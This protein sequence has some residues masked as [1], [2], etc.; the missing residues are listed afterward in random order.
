MGERENGR[1]EV[2]MQRGPKEEERVCARDERG[3]Y[4]HTIKFILVSE[5]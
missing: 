3:T 1:K 5:S 2:S 4:V